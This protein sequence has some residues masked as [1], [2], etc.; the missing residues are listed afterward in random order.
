MGDRQIL[1]KASHS[2]HLV[3]V[4]GVY[5]TTGT[6]EQTGLEHGVSKEVEH[7]SHIAYAA[8]M[9]MSRGAICEIVEKANTRLMSLW[10]Q[11]TDAA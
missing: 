8:C 10:A 4:N 3:A 11:A 7:R 9:L 6:E 2:L 1:A 5:N